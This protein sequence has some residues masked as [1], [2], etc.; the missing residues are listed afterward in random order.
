MSWS[1]RADFAALTAWIL[2]LLI[3]GGLAF[4]AFGING[5]DFRTFYAA[6]DVFLSGGDPYD[7]DQ[8][9]PILERET[10]EIRNFPFFHPP[11]MAWVG[12]FFALFPYWVARGLWLLLNVGTWVL[13]CWL[14]VKTLG[15]PPIGWRRWLL[16]LALT[17]LLAWFTWRYEQL[18]VILFALLAGVWFLLQGGRGK[19]AE[20]GAGVLLALLLSKPTITLLIVGLLLLWCLRHKRWYV[21][22]GFGGMLLVLLLSTGTL[23]LKYLQYLADP[24]FRLRLSYEM[25]G[26]GQITALRIATTF[27]D[28][29]RLFALPEPLILGVWVIA[30]ILALIAAA[31]A[32]RRDRLGLLLVVS[33][34]ATF[35]ITPYALQYDFPLLVIPLIAA[36]H[37]IFTYAAPRHRTLA[38]IIGFAI[39]TVPLWENSIAEGFWIV[40]G[41]TLFVV[42]SLRTGRFVEVGQAQ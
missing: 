14:V 34:L 17:Y 21:M 9:I 39:L 20:I 16:L 10:G 8:L 26:A 33:V 36:L 4:I 40:V 38:F 27:S 25:D 2:T 32:L 3:M 12:A 1:Q 28:W 42:L 11:W 18:G 22:V 6:G 15:F 31:W 23:T 30:M 7:Y 19:K 29:L 41:I 37:S 5:H 35:W 24:A 13:G